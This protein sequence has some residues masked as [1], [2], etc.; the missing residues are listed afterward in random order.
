MEVM[1][2]FIFEIIK[3]C[4]LSCFY[5]TI[6]LLTFLWLGKMKPNSWFKRVAEK[7]KKFWFLS[8]LFISIGLFIF[9]FT[10]W[11]FHGL[12]DGPRVP[13]GHGLIVDNTDW[14]EYGYVNE[15][16]TND[17]IS[18]EMTKF[19]VTNDKLLGN[20]DS[21]FYT[22]KNS[23]FIYDMNTKYLQE[24]Q[25]KKDYEDFALKND[26]PLENEFMTFEQNYQKRWGG[27][28]FW[29]LP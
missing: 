22:Y 8:G 10:Y 5:A 1:V 11:G 17:S 27:W 19:K 23:Y 18:V 24:F 29:L 20:L 16:Q 9:M 3:I 12:G 2:H 6:T 4:I 7:K 21:R 25:T 13:I 15:I 28:W 26:L 14:T